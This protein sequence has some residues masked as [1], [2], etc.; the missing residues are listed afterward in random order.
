MHEFVHDGML[1]VFLIKKVSLA[2]LYCACVGGETAR[3]SEI[4]WQTR[5]V[6]WRGVCTSI[7][8]MFEHELY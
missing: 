2:Q 7:S 5:E 4:A 6:S 8:E 3:M 1:H